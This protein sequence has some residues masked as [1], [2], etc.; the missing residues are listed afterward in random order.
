MADAEVYVN[1]VRIARHRDGYTPFAAQL[2]GGLRKA[3][4]SSS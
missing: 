1:G 2:T 3:T 4:I